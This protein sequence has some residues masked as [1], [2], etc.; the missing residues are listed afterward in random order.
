MRVD[1]QILLEHTKMDEEEQELSSS[2]A[3]LST[4]HALQSNLTA[5]KKVL[6]AAATWDS[7]MA[8]IP[9]LLAQQKLSEAVNALSQLEHGERACGGCRIETIG[10]RQLPRFDSRYRLYFTRN[11]CTPCR[12]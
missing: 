7:T 2:L 8:S 4:L 11:S 6:T 5:A 12:I 9:P 1:A 10:S 3:S